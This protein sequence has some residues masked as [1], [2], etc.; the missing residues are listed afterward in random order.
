M[1]VFVDEENDADDEENKV[2]DAEVATGRVVEVGNSREDVEERSV[3]EVVT[4]ENAGS[5]TAVGSLTVVG[6]RSVVVSVAL[7]MDPESLVM[8]VSGSCVVSALGKGI[9]D[10]EPGVSEVIVLLFCFGGGVGLVFVES[11]VSTWPVVRV[12]WVIG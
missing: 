12:L 5:E 9:S 2:G 10:G 7:F 3:E 8:L 1:L 6:S 4:L 11:E